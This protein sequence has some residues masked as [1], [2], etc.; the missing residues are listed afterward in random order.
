MSLSTRFRTVVNS[1]P[2]RRA[3]A[4]SAVALASTVVLAAPPAHAASTTPGD[5][6]AYLTSSARVYAVDDCTVELGWVYDSVPAP[7]WRHIGGVRVNCASRHSVIDATVA[8]Y[9][10][11]G[12]RWVQYG[13]G[14]Y[15]VRYNS[16]GSGFGLTGILR[17]P[18]Y[19]VGTYR[20]YSWMV[21]ATVR[22]DRT[23]LT[24]Y[25]VPVRNTTQ[26]C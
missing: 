22:T 12:S 17:T 6:S 4:A 3:L 13:N 21:G 14:T 10:Y 18:A 1:L 23:G 16:T 2:R 11:N 20:A 8:L 19:C 9:Y 24:N 7:N 25:T 5:F 26:G 15:G